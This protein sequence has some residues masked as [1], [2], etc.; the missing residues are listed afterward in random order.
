MSSAARAAAL[1]R[2]AF[3]CKCGAGRQAPRAG[4]VESPQAYQVRL[5]CARSGARVLPH[6]LA[7][8]VADLHDLECTDRSTP[9][10]VVRVAIL[11]GEVHGTEEV[12]ALVADAEVHGGL[13]LEQLPHLVDRLPGRMA[14]KLGHACDSFRDRAYARFHPGA[15][16]WLG[17]TPG[18][19]TA[20]DG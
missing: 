18:V 13:S 7:A 9:A 1:Y 14:M 11:D 10:R 20:S 15:I 4:H 6:L 12:G 17:D 2:N 3:L 16:P 5:G 19:A 8:T